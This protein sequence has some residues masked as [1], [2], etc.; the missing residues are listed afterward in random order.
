MWSAGERRR[1]SVDGI[2]CVQGVRVCVLGQWLPANTNR[3][4][5]S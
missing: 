2:K 5:E 1:L 3:L 4:C